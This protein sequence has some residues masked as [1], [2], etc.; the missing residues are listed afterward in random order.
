MGERKGVRTV[1]GGLAVGLAWGLL[2]AL[3]E[4]LPLLLQGSPGAYT[5]QRLLGLAYLAVLYGILGASAGG[6]LGAGLWLVTRLAPAKIGDPSSI[7]AGVLA[8]ATAAVLSLQRFGT[9]PAA[10]AGGLLLAAGVGAAVAWLLTRAARGRVWPRPAIRALA[11]AIFG[12]A[13]VALLAVAGYRARLRDLP[14]FNA[15]RTVETAS[16]ERPNLVLITAGGIRADHLGTYGYGA[17][18]EPE[19]SPN[20]DALAGRGTRFEVALAQASWD[21]PSLASLLTS[22][23]PTELGIDCQATI[24]C[25]P[26]LDAERVT[27]A[28]ALK[29]AGYGTQAFVTSSWLSPELGFD[30]GFDGFDGVREAQPFDL[31]QLL[32]GTLGRLLGCRRDSDVCRRLVDGYGRLFKTAIP[33]GWGGDH[34][35]ARVGR[36]LE[37]HGRERFFLWVHYTEA[38][39]PYDLEDPFRPIARDP[40]ASR[41]RALKGLGYWQLGDPF[42]AREDLMPL[43][44][45][46]LQALYDGEVHRVDRLVG[47]VTG[48]LEGYGLADRTVVVFTSDHG[49]EFMEHGGYTYGHSLYDEVLRVPLIVAGPGTGT[50]GQVVTAPVGLVDVAPTLLA[51]AGVPIPAEA[52][53]RSLVP[54]LAGEAMEARPVYSESLYRVPQALKAVR[55]EG[56][57]LILDAGNGS[58]E[59]YDLEADPG[60]QRDIS[61]EAGEVTEALRGEVL[62]WMAHTQQVAGELPRAMPPVDVRDVA[63]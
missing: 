29:Q 1:G 23:Y 42:T 40:L 14:A 45:A 27:L 11:A 32:D 4:G 17:E 13:L 12:V 47:G 38:L 53:G 48:L 24:G 10:L 57:K 28:E 60:E 37:L 8:A 52:E 31:G 41:P 49:Q 22:L 54:A 9:G 63:W 34:V 56:Y 18:S 35:N 30:Q 3:L 43:D 5:G 50:A 51:L 36:F 21:E 2:G 6:L 55:A 7:V 26:H 62:D 16:A 46:G 19:I 20:L 39:P 61:G 15:S 44:A 25:R 59:L 33:A 58:V